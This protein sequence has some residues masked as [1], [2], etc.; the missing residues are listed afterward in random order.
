M[1]I[2]NAFLLTLLAL[3]VAGCAT[4]KNV[5][6][7]SYSGGD[8]STSEQAV[9]IKDAKYREAGL[10]GERMWLE[11]KYPGCRQI[12]K[13]ALNSGGRIYELVE[14]TTTDGQSRQVYFDTTEFC[15]K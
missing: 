6:R 2:V 7:L 4:S 13:K 9:V 15:A 14:V 1:R 5:Q 11:Q 12:G 3:L 10:V 8:G